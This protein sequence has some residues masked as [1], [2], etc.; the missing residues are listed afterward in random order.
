MEL[1]PGHCN[2][3]KNR[4]NRRYLSEFNQIKGIKILLAKM[5]KVIF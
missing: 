1:N 4:F 2:E 5:P 3:I